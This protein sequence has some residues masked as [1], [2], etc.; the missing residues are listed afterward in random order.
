M[1]SAFV[2]CSVPIVQ[3]LLSH[4]QYQCLVPL[5]S[6][7]PSSVQCPLPYVSAQCPVPLAQCMILMPGSLWPLSGTS[8]QLSLSGGCLVVGTRGQAVGAKEVGTGQQM[9]R[10]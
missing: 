6:V 7:S 10:W 4:A 2:Q 5:C 1:P 3:C 8:V 9:L